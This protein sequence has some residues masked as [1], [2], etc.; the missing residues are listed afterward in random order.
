MSETARWTAVAL[1]PLG[2]GIFAW[3]FAS[4]GSEYRGGVGLYDNHRLVTTGAYRFV[5]HPIYLSFILVMALGTAVSANWVLATSGLA[6]VVLIAIIRIPIE[7]RE[8]GERF[9]TRWHRYKV[10][11]GALVPRIR[12]P[13]E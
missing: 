8:L 9:A 4:L 2:I 1:L 11:T 12:T 6:L 5:R 13:G 10:S 3:S 7:E